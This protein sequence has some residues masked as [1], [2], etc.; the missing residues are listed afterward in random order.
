MIF[1][2]LAVSIAPGIFLLWFYLQKDK[3]EKEPLQLILKVFFLGAFMVLPAAVIEMLFAEND[4]MQNGII[5]VFIYSFFCIGMVE[6]ILKLLTVKLTAYNSKELN[7]PMDGIIYG[8]SAALGFATLEN[9][10]Y[11]FQYGISTGFIRAV[12]AVPLHTFCGGV[13]GY[14][15][16]QAKFNFNKERTLIIKGFIY[17]SLIHGFYDFFLFSGEHLAIFSVPLV[18]WSY[19]NVKKK[20]IHAQSQSP[21]KND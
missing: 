1:L 17:A 4:L 5:G 12:L 9:I 14:Y 6:E 10:F 20:I 11:V 21:F 7:E 15:L 18:V 13:M 16:G 8:I 2:I 3:Y 19:I